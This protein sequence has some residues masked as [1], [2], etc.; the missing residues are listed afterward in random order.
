MTW[1][2]RFEKAQ[3]CIE[4]RNDSADAPHGREDFV[5]QQFSGGFN[6]VR[7]IEDELIE[8]GRLHARTFHDFSGGVANLGH[9]SADGR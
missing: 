9:V 2:V 4:R 1:A 3:A 5:L 7:G 8:A 6:F